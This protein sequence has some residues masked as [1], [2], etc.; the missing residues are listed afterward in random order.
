[1]VNFKAQLQKFGNKGEKTGW[2]YIQ[3][4][5]L[6]TQQLRPGHKK[7][8]RV[9]GKIDDY[10]IAAVA[11]T[12]IGEGN[13]IMAVNAAM[14]KSLKKIYGAFVDVHLTVDVQ[15]LVHDQDLIACLFDEKNAHDYY[16]SLPPSHQNWFSNWVKSARTDATK[17]KRIAAV[18]TSCLHKL[19][20]AEMMQL[21]RDKKFIQ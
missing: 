15:E 3:V 5:A 13:F 10:D 16:K 17:T 18:V 8:F 11:L 14:R 21:Y 6:I 12:P 1:M 2:T 4:P 7:S 19:S 20:F 9:K